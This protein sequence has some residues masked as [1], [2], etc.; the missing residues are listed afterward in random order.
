MTLDTLDTNPSGYCRN[1]ASFPSVTVTIVWLVSLFE[2]FSVYRSEQRRGRK[3]SPRLYSN[4][5]VFLF[6]V[7]LYFQ[8]VLISFDSLYGMARRLL[9]CVSLFHCCSVESDSFQEHPSNFIISGCITIPVVIHITCVQ[10]W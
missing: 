7:L 9:L 4:Y 5:S 3:K 10:M 1:C 8:C 6:V 2:L